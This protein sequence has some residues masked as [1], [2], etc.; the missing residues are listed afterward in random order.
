[1]VDTSK[2]AVP[3]HWP[4]FSMGIFSGDVDGGEI[5]HPQWPQ[6]LDNPNIPL[7]SHRNYH[8]VI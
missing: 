1:M 8:L 4:F 3:V 2:K 5:V 7:Q 6:L